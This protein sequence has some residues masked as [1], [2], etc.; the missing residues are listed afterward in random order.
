MIIVY[1]KLES[2][3]NPIKFNFYKMTGTWV[4]GTLGCSVKITVIKCVRNIQAH[5]FKNTKK[6]NY[7]SLKR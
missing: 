4:F 6:Y 3:V 5:N 7:K 2:G 1:N